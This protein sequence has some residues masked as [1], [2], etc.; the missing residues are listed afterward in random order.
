MSNEDANAGTSY[1][2]RWIIPLV[3]HVS[4]FIA[5][6]D[7]INLAYALPK[8]GEFYGWTKEELAD[9]GSLLL[10]A[11]YVSYAFA[12][13]LLS[14]IASR[15][16][17]RKS[18]I[19]LVVAFSVFTALGAPLSFSLPLFIGT[20][21]LL[22][23]GEGVHF[24]VMNGLMKNWFP[25]SERSRANAIWIFGANLATVLAPLVLVPI[26]THFGWRIMLIGCGGLGLFITIPLLYR[27]VF[28]SPRDAPFITPR[29]VAY[30]ET[31]R[32]QGEPTNV[33][34]QFLRNPAF[35]LAVIGAIANNYCVYGI[36][37]W[38]P[39]YLVQEKNLD[40]A[41]LT[42][43]APLPYIAAFV[44]FAAC[45]VLGDKTNRRVIIAAIGFAA[46]ALSVNLV[47]FDLSV[48]LT[49]ASFSAATLF[50]SAYISQEFAILQRILPAAVIGRAAGIYNGLSMLFGAVGGT[51]LLGQIVSIT[52]SYN[53]G[54]SSVVMAAIVGALMMA[55]LSRFV[56]Y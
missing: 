47:T 54:L 31:H 10:G 35:W 19:T 34:W 52:G 24:P 53:A 32:E 30:I 4:L 44:G 40:F 26:I 21:V 9:K 5:F 43:A 41:Q 42:Y 56:R 25:L 15:W 11:F 7:R 18:L 27:F 33:D 6:L 1:D 48:P 13:L 49:I 23:I 37:N 28:D 3:L 45:A 50:Q 39:T 46:T 16:G 51:V 38:L 12:N 22:G 29:E 14:G 8:L 20:R 2:R 55:I 36:L 17:L